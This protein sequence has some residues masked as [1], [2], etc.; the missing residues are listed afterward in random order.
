MGYNLIFYYSYVNFRLIIRHFYDFFGRPTYG[1]FIPTKRFPKRKKNDERALNELFFVKLSKVISI[2][3]E[4]NWSQKWRQT[5]VKLESKLAFGIKMT[6]SVTI[7]CPKVPPTKECGKSV[8]TRLNLKKNAK[9]PEAISQTKN[10]AE[11]IKKT[12]FEAQK[13]F[14]RQGEG[15]GRGE[16]ETTCSCFKHYCAIYRAIT[17]SGG[18]FLC[19]SLVLV[20]WQCIHPPREA[21]CV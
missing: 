1:Q 6:I 9:K 17:C 14:A 11:K 2:K 13:S 7:T 10:F 5:G 19:F 12:F 20:R 8:K 16:I 21:E 4:L 3:P 15:A 18:Y